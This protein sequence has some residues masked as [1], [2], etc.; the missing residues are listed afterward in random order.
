MAVTKKNLLL[1]TFS[2]LLV[3]L[4][5]V[6]FLFPGVLLTLA[7]QAERRAA[8]FEQREVDIVG[9]RIAY[10]IG[11]EGDVLVLLHGFG[12]DKDNWTRVAKYLTPH[13][14][15]IAPDLPGF[16]DSSREP[17]ARYALD[18][19]VDNVDAFV[20]ALDLSAFHIGGN[21][22]GGAIAGLYAARHPDMVKSVW[23]LAPGGV[24]TAEPSEL[25][26]LLGQG[27]NP[28]LIH[29]AADFE[30]LLDFVFV[31]IP[32]I[33]DPIVGY[34]TEQAIAQRRFNEKI[35][36]DFIANPASLE[37]E[38]Q[39]IQAP[40]LITWGDQDRLLHVSGAAILDALIPDSHVV[41]M[42]N[43]GHIPM[44]ERP[45]ESAQQ[46]LRLHGLVSE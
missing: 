29:T 22:M 24:D 41:I 20:Q 16:G 43:I 19:Q 15:V 4:A 38:A 14:H 30:R 18:D 33:P 25:D 3:G 8:D 34:L 13:F 7:T 36:Q 21:S 35:I 6:Y 23:L 11:G 32:A 40:T 9:H 12:A 46:F 37:S 45:Y 17:K 26:G 1:A 31:E 2:V 28:L 42:K 5:V 27:D 39:K 44:I 10:L